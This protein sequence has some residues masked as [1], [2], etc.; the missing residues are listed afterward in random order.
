MRRA[1][2]WL[3]A[4]ALVVLGVETHTMAGSEDFDAGSSLTTMGWSP[5]RNGSTAGPYYVENAAAAGEDGSYALATIGTGDS[6]TWRGGGL[7]PLAPCAGSEKLRVTYRWR[8]DFG[9]TGGTAFG[10]WSSGA[11]PSAWGGSTDGWLLALIHFSDAT[12]A[13]LQTNGDGGVNV[14]NIPNVF[15]ATG[16][17][18][19]F[20][21][22]VQF[23]SGFDNPGLDGTNPFG[24]WP[25]TDNTVPKAGPGIIRD[26]YI[27]VW[28][29]VD[30]ASL[31]L[32]LDLQNIG[33]PNP[34]VYGQTATP[35]SAIELQP[36][37]VIDDITWDDFC[38]PASSAPQ[39]L[40]V[41]TPA[42]PQTDCTPQTQ[43]GNGGKGNAG[44]N[45]GG[46]GWTRS[47]FGPWGTGPQHA[48]P[49]AGE[50]LTGKQGVEVWA[51]FVHTDYPSGTK[52][53]YRQAMVPLADPSTY[54]GGYKK[55]GLLAVGAIEHAIGNEQGGIEA[56]TVDLEYTGA[57]D[58]QFH[59]LLADQELEGDEIRIKAA[60][61]AARA[62]GTAPRVLMRSVVMRARLQSTLRASIH[63]VDQLFA[64]GMP[65]GPGAM[66]PGRTYADLGRGAPQMTADT[67][68]TPIVPP[69]GERSDAG[70]RDPITNEVNPKGL[71][72]GVYLGMFAVDGLT[73]PDPSTGFASY[74]EL[75]AAMQVSKDANTLADDWPQIGV[76]DAAKLQAA[77]SLP[78]TYAAFEVE[79]GVDDAAACM[80]AGTTPAP[81]SNEWGI[82]AFGFGPAHSWLGVF[83]SDLGGGIAE[84]THDRTELDFMAR[85]G[86][87]LLVPGD[88]VCPWTA[89]EITNPDTGE[90]FGL[91]AIGVRGPLLD[92]HLNG[93]V[94]ITANFIGLEHVGDGSGDPVGLGFD[95]W[96]HA[97]ENF[98]L[99][100][101]TAGPWVTTSTAKKW[102]DGTPMV[103]SAAFQ[104]LQA[105]SAA[106]LGGDGLYAGWYQD[107]PVPT[108]E[109]M[110]LLGA[111]TD[112]RPGFDRHGRFTVFGVDEEADTSAWTR[113]NH[114]TDIFGPVEITFGEERQTICEAVCD[115]DPDASKFRVAP[116]QETSSSGYTRYKNRHKPGALMENGLLTDE[117][118]LRWV[119]QRRL[120]RLQ[121][122]TTLITVVGTQDWLDL[123]V[124]DGVLL[125]TEDGPG[126]SGYVDRA[127]IILRSWYDVA[128]RLVRLT[129]WDVETVLIATRF[130]NGLARIPSVTDDAGG[131]VVTDDADLA[132]LVLT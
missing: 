66:F 113:I 132:P 89:F 120:A 79:V 17:F 76:L 112:S 106:S 129:L 70:A 23:S 80:A 126:A 54:E 32:V 37:G 116:I 63:A 93:V 125:T 41:A 128:S 64:P 24:N 110:A 114:V 75:R 30:E 111:W 87:D 1:L 46:V 91:A 82:L 20:R 103:D 95:A 18:G 21:V 122:G 62:A 14:W 99:A 16:A 9:T 4:L 85:A 105:R 27:K 71:V 52:T 26:G 92:D 109:M 65:F 44:C 104:A 45:T 127:C 86:S 73:T 68:A 123:D 131:F 78:D 77:D 42:T 13:Q 7:M 6:G 56:S 12:S 55:D 47:Y 101:K 11:N 117:D 58:R 96:H 100:G 39:A 8:R 98:V 25:G 28:S 60:S 22:E 2:G 90:T 81:T 57:L 10:V 83:G 124:G 119:L 59:T 61:D 33:I 19:T 15:P 72:P 108:T 48:E 36:G 34:K 31:S 38:T 5:I 84:N 67:K 50:T 51:E 97:L 69:Y 88:G 115:W 74:A 118:Q 29:G 49:A 53:T 107:K 102:D 43:V 35:Y 3:L 130:E 40:P 121:H 94:N